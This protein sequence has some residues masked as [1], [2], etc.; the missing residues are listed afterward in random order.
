[1]KVRDE[2]YLIATD[3]ALDLD[4]RYAAAR[5]LQRSRN[6]LRPLPKPERPL[7]VPK[8]RLIAQDALLIL[9]RT[10]ERRMKGAAAR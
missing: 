7:R 1:M 6:G 8:Q 3:T 5:Q 9:Y 10:K 2:L 4:I